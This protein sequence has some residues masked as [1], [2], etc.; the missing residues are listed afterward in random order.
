MEVS[1]V[2]EHILRDPDK[3]TTADLCALRDAVGRE[4]II[5]ATHGEGIPVAGNRPPRSVYEAAPQMYKALKVALMP[6]VF[7]HAQTKDAGA[8]VVIKHVQAALAAAD[9]ETT[10]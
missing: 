5:R 6:L 3:Y 2:L 9:G 4:L 7:F 8:R 10:L 1:E